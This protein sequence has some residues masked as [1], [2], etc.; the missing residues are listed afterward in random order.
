MSIHTRIRELHKILATFLEHGEPGVLVIRCTDDEILYIV[1][2]LEQL[3]AESLAD[4]VL[5]APDPFED[6]ASYPGTVFARITAEFGEATSIPPDHP[7]TDLSAILVDLLQR[8]PAGDH[9]QL[10]AL[11]PA[12]VVDVMAFAALFEP[13]LIGPFPA[14]LRLVV[15]EDPRHP[16][17]AEHSSSSQVFVYKFSLPESL[18]VESIAASALDPSR[19]PDERAQAI[20]QLA[21]REIGF[22]HH[23]RAI[24]GCDAAIETAQNPA[25]L[26]LALALRADALRAADQLQQ[27]LDSAGEALRRALHIDAL[28]LIHHSAMTLGEIAHQLGRFDDAAR[29]FLLA[30]RAAGKHPAAHALAHERRAAILTEAP[31]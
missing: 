3:D 31:C 4:R 27:A 12:R 13:L 23:E 28:P 11:V 19:T 8:L 17:S 1:H 25:I 26:A 22:G 5:I 10:C 2:V 6:P 29:C 7:P 20:L 16:L 18:V 9:R 21:V 14:P 24:V 30:E 15:R